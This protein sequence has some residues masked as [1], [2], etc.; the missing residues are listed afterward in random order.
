MWKPYLFRERIHM[1]TQMLDNSPGQVIAFAEFVP[2][3]PLP[4]PSYE[5]I[6]RDYPRIGLPLEG[7]WDHV[8]NLQEDGVGEEKTASSTSGSSP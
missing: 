3:D 2:S 7:E 8:D 5:K 6:I 4:V 1:E